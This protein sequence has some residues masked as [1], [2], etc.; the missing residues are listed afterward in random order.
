MQQKGSEWNESYGLRYHVYFTSSDVQRKDNT[1]LAYGYCF[2]A[3][4][5]AP[6]NE[7]DTSAARVK[8]TK[9]LW[10]SR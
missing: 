7:V 9:V 6:T 8:E 3:C 10:M 4:G 1:E 5:A 2:A